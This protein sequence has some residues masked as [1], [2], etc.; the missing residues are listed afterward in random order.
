MSTTM[1]GYQAGALETAVYPGQNTI[2]GVEYNLFGLLGE[3]GELANKYKKIMRNGKSP[4][5]HHK[6]LVSEL[7]DV[8]W[9]AA[10]LANELGYDLSE[11]AEMN[12]QKLAARKQA[13]ELKEHARD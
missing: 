13:G 9:Y 8:L 2:R 4:Y 1:S 6:D 3:A 5:D 12:Q 11:V 10:V 7:G